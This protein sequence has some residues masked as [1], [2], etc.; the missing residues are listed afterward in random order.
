MPRPRSFYLPSSPFYF[1]R[2]H[3]SYLDY[4]VSV[5]TFISPC[6]LT[7]TSSMDSRHSHRKTKASPK[8]NS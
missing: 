3:P 6:N 8:A 2:A 7:L 4:Y 5:P 1:I